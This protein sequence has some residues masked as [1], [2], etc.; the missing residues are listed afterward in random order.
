L[1]IFFVLCSV[2]F[3]CLL[4]L[5][6]GMLRDAEAPPTPP[7]VVSDISSPQ[8]SSAAPLLPELSP[9]GVTAL[10]VITEDASYAFSYTEK[11]HVG[12]NGRRADPD[13][14]VTLLKQIIELPVTLSTPFVPT[15]APLATVE[16]TAGEAQIRLWFYPS[17]ASE[18]HTRLICAFGPNAS[19]VYH[20][21]D[22]WRL[23]TMLMTCEGT[24]ILDERGHEMPL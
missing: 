21:T 8:T 2:L 9:E 11:S 1:R 12:L 23:G 7:G 13:V 22:A 15:D 19:R 16:L 17:E 14:F 4:A 5:T 18:A 10:S 3:L 20:I 24:R 6:T